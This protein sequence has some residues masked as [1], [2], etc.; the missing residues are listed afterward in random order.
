M[1]RYLYPLLM[2]ALSGACGGDGGVNGPVGGRER[3]TAQPISGT[4]TV[5]AGIYPLSVTATKDARLIVP[6]VSGSAAV[7][8]LVMLHGAGGDEVPVDVVA[9][10]AALHNIAVL[11]PRSRAST[12]DL[13]AGGFG[14]DVGVID[15]ALEETFRRVRVDPDRIALAGFSD[16]ASYALT[17]GIANGDLFSHLIAFAP[18]FMSPVNRFG[19]PDIFIAHGSEDVITSPRNS[20][21]NIVPFLRA[22]GYTVRFHGFTGGHQVNAPEADAAL[23]WFLAR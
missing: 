19:S 17:L 16:G 18:G 15:R 13:A 21:Q 10:A 2:L 23:A 11:I 7:P 14:D 4:T 1:S 22:L 8:L 6:Q 5:A 9:D 12:W 3:L 20:E